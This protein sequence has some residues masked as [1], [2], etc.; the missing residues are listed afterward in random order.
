MRVRRRCENY[1][2]HESRATNNILL[3]FDFYISLPSSLLRSSLE[4][5]AS[6]HLLVFGCLFLV[7]QRLGGWVLSERL[8]NKSAWSSS[9]E[10]LLHVFS[11]VINLRVF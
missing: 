4:F 6:I 11:D 9:S 8:A 1:S 10:V 7:G 2:K 5:F 3:L